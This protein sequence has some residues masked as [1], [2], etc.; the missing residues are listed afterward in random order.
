MQIAFSRVRHE[1]QSEMEW[2]VLPNTLKANTHATRVTV[3]QDEQTDKPKPDKRQ[4]LT[5]ACLCL[6]FKDS[7]ELRATKIESRNEIN[8]E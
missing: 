3:V 1:S 7:L 6:L 2:L 5:L 4:S 8:N